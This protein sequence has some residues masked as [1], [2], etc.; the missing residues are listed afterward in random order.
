MGILV[1]MLEIYKPELS[2]NRCWMGY[3]M[4]KNNPY[5]FHHIKEVRNGGITDVSNGAILTK[6]SH[7][8]LN[9][10]DSFFHDEYEEL[11]EL[12][13]LLNRTNAPPTEEHYM[14]VRKI[15]NKVYDIKQRL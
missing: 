5:S 10:L 1:R 12:F 14:K 8:Y 2:D 11:N 6:K 9:E 3:K 15:L 7:R 13:F 4:T